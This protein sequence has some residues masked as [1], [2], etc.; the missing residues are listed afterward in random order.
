M[1]LC[2][3]KIGSSGQNKPN[4]IK[5]RARVAIVNEQ[6]EQTQKAL[7]DALSSVVHQGN[8]YWREHSGIGTWQ[9]WA[10]MAML[11]VPLVVLALKMDRSQALRLGFYGFA[12]HVIATYTD[13]YG[14]THQ[15]WSYPY[16]ILPFP[17][18]SFG[19]DA[20]LIPVTYMLVY[21]WTIRH[22]KN[23]YLYLLAISI[24]FSLVFKPIMGLFGLFWLYHFTYW[25]LVPIYYGGGLIAKWITDLFHW[26]ERHAR[27]T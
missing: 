8:D 4:E 2:A 26:L 19:L 17:S 11:V 12:I 20:S 3:S 18:M 24:G 13:L 5:S 6:Q 16:R 22:R 27:R 25:Q 7:A 15:M 23:Y 9:F 21:Q 14:T 10:V 1:P